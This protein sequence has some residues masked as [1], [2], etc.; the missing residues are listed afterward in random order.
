MRAAIT[1]SLVLVLTAISL[2]AC[3]SG[4]PTSP[5]KTLQRAHSGAL[6]VAL[7]S[8]D[9]LRRDDGAFVLEFKDSTG[10][11]VDVGTVTVNAAMTMPGMAPMFGASTVKPTA[12]K[13][14]YDVTSE[15]SMAGTWRF[16]VGW[17]GPAGRGSTSMSSN[18]S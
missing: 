11:L 8:R 2:A 17:D 18:V 10:Q 4:Q 3:R 7:L 1:V 9:T 16:T 15:L 13:G 5:L 6:D 12:T 14:R